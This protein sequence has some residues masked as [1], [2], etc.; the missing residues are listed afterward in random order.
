VRLEPS[1]RT[2]VANVGQGKLEGNRSYCVYRRYGDSQEAGQSRGQRHRQFK[3]DRSSSR[4]YPIP[5]SNE[6]INPERVSNLV[7]A[8]LKDS[9]PV[10]VKTSEQP[11]LCYVKAEFPYLTMTQ[12]KGK[13]GGI[14]YPPRS[15][16]TG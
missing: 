10:F 7:E 8:S 16:Q 12:T 4:N 1:L 14:Y 5:S 9:K 2:E 3:A 11:S 6:Q 15:T 13:H